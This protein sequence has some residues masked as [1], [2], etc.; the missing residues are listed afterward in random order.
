MKLAELVYD[1]RTK[2]EKIGNLMSFYNCTTCQ[3][4]SYSCPN[5]LKIDEVIMDMRKRLFQKGCLPKN[6]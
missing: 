5:E 3:Q 1:V 2:G 4:C 6:S